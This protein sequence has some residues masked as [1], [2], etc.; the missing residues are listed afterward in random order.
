MSDENPLSEASLQATFN[1]LSQ[2]YSQPDVALRAAALATV[3]P[4]IRS[5]FRKAVRGPWGASLFDAHELRRANLALDAVAAT[6]SSEA[7]VLHAWIVEHTPPNDV[8]PSCP[9]VRQFVKNMGLKMAEGVE[10]RIASLPERANE[11]RA[12]AH[13]AR[14]DPAAL[15]ARQI[16]YDPAYVASIRAA[17][18]GVLDLVRDLA[19][20]EASA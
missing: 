16:A 7:T 6:K 13:Q 4:L 3:S 17:M 8:V 11:L 9:W 15:V 5:V 20:D 18:N 10:Q 12:L 19:A 14:R 2:A 1:A